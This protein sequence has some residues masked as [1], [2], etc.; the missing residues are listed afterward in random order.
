MKIATYNIWN[1]EMG[2]PYRTGCI[3]NEIADVNADVICLQE[4][5]SK[6]VAGDI[7][8]RTGYPYSFFD[9]YRDSTE[10]LC[11]LS[12][13]SFDECESWLDSA[14]AIYCSFLYNNKSV[15]IVNVHLPWDSIAERE[16]QI[17]DIIA[18]IGNKKCDHT[19]M[20]G[21]FNCTETSDVHRFL[22]GECL[23]SDKEA[24]P[25][26]YDLALSY[27]ELTDS[28]VGST[29]NFRENPR[30]S[31]NTIELNSRFDRILLRNTYPCEFPMLRNCMI[32][33]KTVY[34][35]INLS[36]SDHYGVMVE[37]E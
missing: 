32:F 8:D 19:Y 26:W 25:R 29:L 21:D 5:H 16:R 12:N 23:L 33:G 37:V 22:M 1:C 24:N 2:M 30:F 36:A 10:G 6:E 31:R 18:A 34:K 7:A 13:I 28:K 17:V 9:N 4:V 35:G 15:S 27:A 20:A 14:N 11:I 3:I